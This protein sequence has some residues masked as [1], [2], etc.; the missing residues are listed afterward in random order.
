MNNDGKKVTTAVFACGRP[1]P[2]AMSLTFAM[3]RSACAENYICHEPV[4]EE[5]K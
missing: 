4:E 5:V 3:L 2:D 1:L